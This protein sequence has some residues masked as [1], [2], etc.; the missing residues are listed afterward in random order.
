MK[1]WLVFALITCMLCGLC[2][3]GGGSSNDNDAGNAPETPKASV[4][5]RYEID[6]VDMA[7]EIFSKEELALTEVN[8][9]NEALVLKDDGTGIWI[10][11]GDEIA[12]VYDDKVIR[13]PSSDLNDPYNYTVMDGVLT[14][15]LGFGVMYYYKLFTE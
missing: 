13:D 10:L 7:G 4:A 9:T 11:E 6:H 5:G 8:G 2:A 14:L 3:C 1:K 12:I 15:D